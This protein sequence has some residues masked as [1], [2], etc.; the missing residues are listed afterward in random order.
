MS[1]VFAVA[2]VAASEKPPESYVAAM[3]TINTTNGAMR[4]HLAA[5]DYA[6]LEG[7]A[8]TLKPALATTLKFW[9]DKKVE[10]AIAWA[11]AVAKATD[12][13]EKG[14][15]DK[16]DEAIGMAAKAIGSSCATCHNAHRDKQPDGTSLIK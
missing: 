11:K 13:L 14:A 16:N 8:K 7:D 6:A 15:K 10:D 12:D 2:A 9:E 1:G 4:Q 5:K 3:K